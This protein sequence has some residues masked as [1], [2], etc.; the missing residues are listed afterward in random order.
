M[1]KSS[2]HK[3]AVRSYLKPCDHKF[4]EGYANIYRMSESKVVA[5]AVKVLRDT[6]PRDIRERIQMNGG[7]LPSEE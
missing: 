3:T 7:A 4:V 1:S 6:T 5:Q 2:S